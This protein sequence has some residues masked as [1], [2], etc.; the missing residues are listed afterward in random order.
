MAKN[1]KRTEWT[2]Q[3]VKDFVDWHDKRM[4]ELGYPP[5]VVR[6]FKRARERWLPVPKKD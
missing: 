1:R 3:Q 5:E 2:E 6:E 4:K